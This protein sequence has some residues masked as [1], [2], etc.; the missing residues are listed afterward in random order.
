MMMKKLLV[1]FFSLLLLAAVTTTAQAAKPKLAVFVVGVDDWKRGDVLAHIAGEELNRNKSYE[2]VTRSGAVQVKLKALRRAAPGCVDGY[3]LRTWGI[4]HG[5]EHICLITTS[6]DKN[7]SAHLLTQSSCQTLCSTSSVSGGLSAVALKE[8]AWSLTG[9]LSSGCSDICDVPCMIYVKGGTFTIGLLPGRDDADGGDSYNA[10]PARENV[11][12]EDF[13][14]GEHE[15]TQRE[16]L[17]VMG[18][19]P[20]NLGNYRSDNRPLVLVSWDDIQG[21]LA[22]LNEKIVNTGMVYK[23]P[24]EAQWE[25]AARGGSVMP[26]NCP[27]G[28]IYSGSNTANNVGYYRENWHNTGHHY[29]PDVRKK[30]PNELGIYDMSGCAWEWC[31]DGWRVSYDDVPDPSFHVIRGGGWVGPLWHT[32]IVSRDDYV[33][34]F[35]EDNVGFRVV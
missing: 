12:V 7:F 2:V 30:Q 24:T 5:V 34:S 13:W 31:E 25:Y 8:L 35:R 29:P 1:S 16:W 17:A 3:A 6:D 23:L 15:V 9:G 33:S 18:S 4:Q 22:K 19:F 10:F 21:Y 20:T 27:N 28:C 11:E 14:I 26:K 32:R